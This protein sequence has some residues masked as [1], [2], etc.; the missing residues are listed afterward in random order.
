MFV[1]VFEKVKMLEI[2]T[3]SNF[4]FGDDAKDLRY[5]NEQAK[6]DFVGFIH[7]MR[8]SFGIIINQY[9]YQMIELIDS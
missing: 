8:F 9:K 4:C 6:I 5:S 2:I 7:W 1:L 3:S